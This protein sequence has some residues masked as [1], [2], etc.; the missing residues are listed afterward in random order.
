MRKLLPIFLLA[1]AGCGVEP[2]IPQYMQDLPRSEEE[3]LRMTAEIRRELGE[4]TRVELVEEFFFVASNDTEAKFI[5]YKG[6]VARVFRYLHADYFTKKPEKPI[7]VYLFKDRQ[8]YEDYC[9]ATYQKPPSTPFGF[10]MSSERKMVM[11]IF[12][13]QGTLAH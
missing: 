3:S 6:M 12:T 8:S 4:G 7:R 11:N 5:E 10:Y 2:S 9:T 1:A 13:G